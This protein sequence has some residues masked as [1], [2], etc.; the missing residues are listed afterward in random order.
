MAEATTL[1]Y[2]GGV[3]PLIILSGSPLRARA[4]ALKTA[5]DRAN[6]DN[7]TSFVQPTPCTFTFAVASPA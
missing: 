2:N 7:S 4:D 3:S 1:L 6:Q 5:L